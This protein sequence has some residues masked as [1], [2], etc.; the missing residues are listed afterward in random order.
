M[1]SAD[2]IGATM[3]LPEGSG[4]I[5]PPT[6]YRL[7]LPE[8]WFRVDIDPERRERSVDVLVNRQFEGVDNAPHLKRQLRESLLAQA[9][10][11][12][13]DGGIELY[14]SLQKAAAFTIPA[15]LL[16]TF[17]PPTG[18]GQLHVQDIATRL[19]SDPELE[20]SVVELSSG[21]A[22]RT[23]RSTGQPDRP[24]PPGMPGGPDETLPSVTLDYQL[25]V[26]RADACLLLTFSTP[27]VQIADAMVELFDAVAASL[28]WVG[29]GT[30]HG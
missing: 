11:A 28:V 2:D 24:A 3:T 12:F 14:L 15:S 20:V 10:A 13:R 27:L 7:L 6:D 23:R 30:D 8:G 17:M 18:G 26:P 19:S 1:R 22:V 25:P 5:A 4:N 21:H 29:G 16:V 9:A